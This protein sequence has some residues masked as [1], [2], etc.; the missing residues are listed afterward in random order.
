MEIPRS[1]NNPQRIMKLCR[2]IAFIFDIQKQ[3]FE[4]IVRNRKLVQQSV[5]L[6]YLHA[7]VQQGDVTEHLLVL[8]DIEVPFVKLIHHFN[9]VVPNSRLYLNN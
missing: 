5:L 9:G 1:V 8:K 7:K 2:L 6:E 3:V 4:I